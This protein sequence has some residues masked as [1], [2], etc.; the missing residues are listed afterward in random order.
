MLLV[1]GG[2]GSTPPLVEEVGEGLLLPVNLSNIRHFQYSLMEQG[3][4]NGRKMAIKW[5][6]G[7][8]PEGKWD[9]KVKVNPSL[10]ATGECH[11]EC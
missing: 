8:S 9:I 4:G 11:P 3:L 2:R 10:Y 6:R 1:D 5:D 7:V